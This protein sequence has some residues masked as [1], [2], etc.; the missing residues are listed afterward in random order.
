MLSKPRKIHSMKLKK[1][2]KKE[3]M[4]LPST[5]LLTLNNPSN[6]INPESMFLKMLKK[7]LKKLKKLSEMEMLLK[8]LKK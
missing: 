1:L 2:L 8:P 5:N 4:K 7:K 3:I 6:K